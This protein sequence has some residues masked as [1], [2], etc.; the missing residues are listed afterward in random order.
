AR[1]AGGS[2]EPGDGGR[3]IGQRDAFDRLDLHCAEDGVVRAGSVR[4]PFNV[5]EPLVLAVSP[6]WD[7]GGA[8]AGISGVR[9][10]H[11]DAVLLLVG[12]PLL[13]RCAAHEDG[14]RGARF[15]NGG[16]SQFSTGAGD[17]AIPI[18]TSGACLSGALD[19]GRTG[20]GVRTSS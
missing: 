8:W 2:A 9:R 1:A 16:D 12:V 5:P 10:E 11:G 15:D 18:G 19:C 17:A 6:F 14:L 13:A 7:S 4:N 3:L 20:A